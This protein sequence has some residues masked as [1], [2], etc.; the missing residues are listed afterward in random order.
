MSPP[1]IIFSKL[2]WGPVAS[3]RFEERLHL[4]FLKWN[5]RQIKSKKSICCCRNLAIC[6]AMSLIFATDYFPYSL[7][8]VAYFSLALDVLVKKQLICQIHIATGFVYQIMF[9][10][11]EKFCYKRNTNHYLR[12]TVCKMWE[13]QMGRKPPI[14]EILLL[15]LRPAGTRV[16]QNPFIQL[17][18]YL[19]LVLLV[20]SGF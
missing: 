4:F 11:S 18:I 20:I 6:F 8:C 12:N 9:T 2:A 5:P 17:M 13:M 15:I 14:C 3:F 1:L 7:L 19:R 16:C 10:E